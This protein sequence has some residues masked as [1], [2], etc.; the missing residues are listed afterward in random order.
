MVS[1]LGLQDNPWV[2]DHYARR[3]MWVTAHIHGTL[4]YIHS[5]FRYLHPILIWRF[6]PRV[7]RFILSKWIILQ[8]FV[9]ENGDLGVPCDHI[10]AIF[11]HLDIT[12]MPA[13]VVLERWSKY[14]RSRMRAFMEKGLFYCDSMVTYHNWT[15]NDL[16]MELCVLA[17]ARVN[18]F[19]GV[20]AKLRNEILHLKGKRLSPNGEGADPL[21][22]FTLEDC[23]SDPQV[24]R[25]YKR[26]KFGVG[27]Y[28]STK[29]VNRCGICHAIGHTRLSCSQRHTHALG[30][31]AGG[32]GTQ[33]RAVY[34]EA[35]YS[36]YRDLWEEI[37]GV[38]CITFFFKID[39]VDW[40]R[41]H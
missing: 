25:H 38:E 28:P 26:R 32:S 8:V 19:V 17:S 27:R 29:G 18:D 24:L 9:H 34:E 1:E 13:S 4:V 7:V 33:R 6:C 22:S 23:V 36:E 40:L 11:L 39:D 16:C 21:V 35:D 37:N 12:E 10:I 41:S 20:I 2:C 14:A 15:L 5:M 3:H 31:T 30:H